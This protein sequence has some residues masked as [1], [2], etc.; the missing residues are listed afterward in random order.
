[1]LICT[2]STFLFEDDTGNGYEKNKYF[3]I[4][5]FNVSK[6]DRIVTKIVQ[7]HPEISR[8]VE[9]ESPINVQ[10]LAIE[11]FSKWG[12]DIGPYAFKRGEFWNGLKRPL[13]IRV[14]NNEILAADFYR[15]MY[16]PT[17]SKVFQAAYYSMQ[18]R[19]VVISQNIWNKLGYVSKLGLVIHENMRHL[20]LGLGHKFNDEILQKATLAILVCKPQFHSFL[21]PLS[22]EEEIVLAR[23]MNLND[24][25]MQCLEESN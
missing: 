5:L 2:K 19:S 22:T 6:I 20:Q 24:R 17:T 1:M 7:T 8:F 12:I 25:I 16:L 14:S 13:Q 10:Q 21:I 23:V 11:I 18:D 9:N 4:D 3:L 15:P